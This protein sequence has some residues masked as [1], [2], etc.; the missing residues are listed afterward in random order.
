MRKL[1]LYLPIFFLVLLSCDPSESEDPVINKPQPV[2]SRE[3][4]V[5]VDKSLDFTNFRAHTIM[6]SMAMDKPNEKL[7]GP[8]GVESVLFFTDVSG[9]ITALVPLEGIKS[10]VTVNAE[11]VTAGVLTLA[12][13]YTSLTPQQKAEL[14][15]RILSEDSYRQLKGIVG[16]ILNK[17]EP[18][19]SA[20]P[21]FINQLSEVNSFIQTNYFPGLNSE[22]GRIN[23]GKEDFPSFISRDNGLTVY[24]QVSSY[25]FIE[26]KPKSGGNSISHILEPN[27]ISQVGKSEVERITLGLK[28]DC[29]EVKINQNDPKVFSENRDQ[30]AKKMAS[31]FLGIIISDF[32]GDGI[33]SCLV[34]LSSTIA[35]K[36]GSEIES[37]TNQSRLEIQVKTTK[38]AA[39]L[40]I[41]AVKEKKC[42][43]LLFNTGAIAKLL[44]S[45]SNLYVNLYKAAKFTY[46]VSE[47]SA[48]AFSLVPSMRINLFDRIQ[49]YEGNLVEACIK[50][51]KAVILDPEYPAGKQVLVKV[52]LDTLSQYA[53]WKKSGFKVS[54][55]LPPLNGQLTAG[56]FATDSEGKASVLWT[57][58]NEPN[59]GVLLTVELR[60]PEGDHLTGSPLTFQTKV[61]QTDS[62]GFYKE[63]ALG[64]WTVNTID[65]GVVTSTF[66]LKLFQN[67]VG[68]YIVKGP[69]GNGRS[70][71]DENG[72]SYYN[73]SWV[74]K[75]VGEGYYLSESGFYHYAFESYRSYAPSLQDARLKYPINFFFTYAEFGQGPYIS[76]KYTKN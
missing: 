16:E 22:G 11:T 69:N 46:E 63:K 49:I 28:D 27:P 43:S 60:D 40:L 6:D 26:F 13:L 51:E 72:D 48:F 21:E 2:G 53:E 7:Y 39:D 34:E 61:T 71:I 68:R 73:I 5:I 42:K 8:Q 70:G 10:E 30:L 58:P 35:L 36:L 67:G 31:A 12:P 9:E 74:I 57:M 20:R 76:R 65:G 37:S 15:Q 45:T 25:V 3:I 23:L 33:N 41:L 55:S 64:S 17:R 44:A 54:W 75:K 47:A 32:T 66:E 14:G 50:V 52:K 19:F 24:N 62:I 1:S 4:N 59:A 38:F 56:S 18:I 29:Y